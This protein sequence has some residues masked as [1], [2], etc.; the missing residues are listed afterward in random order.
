M[1]SEEYKTM[2]EF[3]KILKAPSFP[4]SV[5][6]VSLMI[7]YFEAQGNEIVFLRRFYK[8]VFF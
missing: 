7:P 2:T 4:T 5:P 1:T 3:A 8:R 6:P